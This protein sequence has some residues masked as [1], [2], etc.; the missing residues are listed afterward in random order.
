MF[1]LLNFDFCPSLFLKSTARRRYI[2]FVL[3]DNGV[4]FMESVMREAKDFH[5]SS[6]K[7]TTMVTINA[8]LIQS[9]DNT[10]NDCGKAQN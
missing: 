3:H 10:Q 9:S 1:F 4:L 2:I 5:E 6:R 7:F 8:T